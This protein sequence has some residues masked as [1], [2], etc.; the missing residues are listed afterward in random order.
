[1]ASVVWT[2]FAV[3]AMLLTFAACVVVVVAG[4]RFVEMA[5][6]RRAQKKAG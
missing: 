1:M 2:V 4:I 3:A 5:C 6:A